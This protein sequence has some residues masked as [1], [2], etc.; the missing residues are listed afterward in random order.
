M[1]R[2]LGA[3][4]AL[5]MATA[6]APAEPA[7]PAVD[8]AA[9]QASL[10]AADKAWSDAY[11][12]ADDKVGSFM[13]AM[14]EDAMVLAP[15]APVAKGPDAIRTMMTGLASLPGFEVVW[16]AESA[17]A[18]ADGTLG[19]TVGSYAMKVPGPD[20]KLVSVSGKYLTVWRKQPDGGWR[21]VAD[22]FN[23]NGPP[24]PA[25]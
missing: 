21:V 2:A 15:D 7:A 3:L 23:A 25:A 22:M 5:A 14:A 24:T 1:R 11:Q 6:C 10:M 17:Q 8:R 16:T 13:S 20:G 4:F 19:F 9:E 12:A 18:S